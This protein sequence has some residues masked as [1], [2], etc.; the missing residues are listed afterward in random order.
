MKRVYVDATERLERADRGAYAPG[1]WARLAGVAAR[2]REGWPREELLSPAALPPTR[3]VQPAEERAVRAIVG[4]CGDRAVLAWPEALAPWG[5]GELLL[6]EW[7][8]RDPG[9]ILVLAAPGRLEAWRRVL[10]GAGPRVHC[11]AQGEPLPDEAFTGWLVDRCDRGLAELPRPDGV[12]R[13]VLLAPRPWP[14]EVGLAAL[15]DW[16]GKRDV[17]LVSLEQAM[18]VEETAPAVTPAA[19]EG[20]LVAVRP[21]IAEGALLAEVAALSDWLVETGRLDA[22]EIAGPWV[23]L[24]ATAEAWPGA[25]PQVAAHLLDREREPLAKARLL[26]LLRAGLEAWEVGPSLEGTLQALVATSHLRVRLAVATSVMGE[27]LAARMPA[28]V[29]VVVDGEVGP[30]A[31]HDLWLHAEPVMHPLDMASRNATGSRHH[32]LVLAGGRLHRWLAAL[33]VRGLLDASG[34]MWAEWV[35]RLPVAMGP[36]DI[37]RN[38]EQAASRLAS[39]RDQLG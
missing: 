8:V 39:I 19:I 17:P 10:E 23:R 18:V 6:R 21:S 4:R 33:D 24:L 27:A 34:P 12:R 20:R 36:V 13:V 5:V 29:D 1:D 9:R 37:W 14:E 15:S 11:I 28:G 32:H 22:V 25:I 16:L 31:V 2:M 3:R 35:A 38:P 30:D 26:S 7:L